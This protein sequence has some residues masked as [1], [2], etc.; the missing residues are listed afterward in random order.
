MKK[1]L[2]ILTAVLA[3]NQLAVAQQEQKHD[4]RAGLI[5][6]KSQYLYLENGVGFDYSS[7]DILQKKI[8][9]K[10]AYIS[11][12]LGSAMSSNAIKQDNFVVGAD[13]RF[14]SDKSLQLLAGI[15][16][17]LFIADYED[18][19]FDVLPNTAM[20]FSIEAGL[21]YNFDFPITTSLTAGYNIKNGNGVDVPGS[22]FPV[23]YRLSVYY[24][25]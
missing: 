24:R 12:R 2:V 25:L 10:A 13:W 14:R 17:G 7:T 8:H 9:F 16:T 4:I 11:S 3:I 20:L 1:L 19:T 18:P 23:F 6:Q 21:S 5:F 15:N 22:L